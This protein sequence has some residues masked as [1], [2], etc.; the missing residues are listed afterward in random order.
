MAGDEEA[1]VE[2]Q[3]R[4]LRRCSLGAGAAEGSERMHAERGRRSIRTIFVDGERWA[5]RV[6]VVKGSIIGLS[7]VVVVAFVEVFDHC[8]QE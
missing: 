7:C 8:T 3:S 6:A 1:D 2:R 4:R 5:R